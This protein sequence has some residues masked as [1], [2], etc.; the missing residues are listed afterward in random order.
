MLLEL[1]GWFMS[2]KS[3]LD[4]AEKRGVFKKRELARVSLTSPL[5]EG[6]AKPCICPSSA[7]SQK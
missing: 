5:Q 6:F 7:L 4:I 1:N 2:G 3:R